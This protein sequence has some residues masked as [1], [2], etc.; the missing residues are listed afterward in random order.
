[1]ASKLEIDTVILPSY[2]ACY[3]I[4]DDCS[5]MEDNEIEMCDQAVEHL[6]KDGWYIV[7]TEGEPYFTNYYR[8]YCPDADCDGGDVLEYVIHRQT[9]KES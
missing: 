9:T 8:L 5:G 3:I 6:A 4:N 1:M 7:S 2:W